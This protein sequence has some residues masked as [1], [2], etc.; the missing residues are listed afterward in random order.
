VMRDIEAGGTVG[1]SP[2]MPTTVWHRQSAI[3]GQMA[4]K[5]G[6]EKG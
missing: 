3:L 4:R 2:A 6:R 5:R 1:G